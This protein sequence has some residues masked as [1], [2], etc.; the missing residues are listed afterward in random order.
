MQAYDE[1]MEVHAIFHETF[2]NEGRRKKYRCE[3]SFND[4]VS[5]MFSQALIMLRWMSKE[6]GRIGLQTDIMHRSYL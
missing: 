3:K 2:S 1:I 6:D 4:A 5:D